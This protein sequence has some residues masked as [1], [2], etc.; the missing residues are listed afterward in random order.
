[1]KIFII[2]Y[3]LTINNFTYTTLNC[4]SEDD[5]T[6]QGVEPGQLP[7]MCPEKDTCCEGLPYTWINDRSNI[8][9]RYN[10]LATNYFR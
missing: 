5:M 6:W 8:V 9:R 3:Y 4:M 2:C 10:G 7:A 1:M